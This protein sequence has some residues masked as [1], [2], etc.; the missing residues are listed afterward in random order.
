MKA[1]KLTE[2]FKKE[3]ISAIENND[4]VRYGTNGFTHDSYE[5][6]VVIT[7]DSGADIV[8]TNT[9]LKGVG[10]GCYTENTNGM[11]RM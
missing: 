2:R 9:V 11:E 6:T 5:E 10:A 7:T 8:I 4:V 3:L 1:I